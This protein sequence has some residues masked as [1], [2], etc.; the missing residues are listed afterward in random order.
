MN[1]RIIPRELTFGAVFN[2]VCNQM[3]PRMILY[4]LNFAHYYHFHPFHYVKYT[5]VKLPKEVGLSIKSNN[6]QIFI[7][8]LS[9]YFDNYLS[10][11]VKCRLKLC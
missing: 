10:A 6:A 5:E 2:T 1:E 3:I 8:M 11:H 7:E 4:K 9:S